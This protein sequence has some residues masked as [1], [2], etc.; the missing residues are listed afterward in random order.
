MK[1]KVK[2]VPQGYHSVTPYL[3]VHAAD[4]AIRFYIKA[5]GATEKFRM[6][7]PD[8]RVAHAEIQIGDSRIMLADE[9]PAVKALSAKTIGATPVSL[10]LYVEDVDATFKA[11]LKAGAIE[12]RMVEDMFYGD[13]TGTVTDP[14]GHVW[15]LAT[16]KEDVTPEE[17]QQRVMAAH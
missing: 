12:T 2:P 13:R 11:A 5:F 14:Y 10:M 7:G 17:M 6:D 1:G 4:E 9:A 15:H 8:H 3:I 16:H